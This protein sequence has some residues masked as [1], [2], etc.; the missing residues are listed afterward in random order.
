MR[1]TF[2]FLPLVAALALTGCMSMAPSY[3]RPQAPILNAWPTGEAYAD[4]K[5]NQQ[6]LPD[7]HEFFTDERLRKVI[8]LTLEN[9]RDYR[10]AM[11]NV[12]RCVMRTTSNA[13]NFCRAFR[14]LVPESI[15]VRQER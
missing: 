13:R 14:G 9:N 4:A 2:K 10:V 1:K 12:Q 11:L 3:E 15:L 6:A 8:E 7:W 5:I